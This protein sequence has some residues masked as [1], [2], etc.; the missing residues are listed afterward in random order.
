MSQASGIHDGRQ[1]RAARAILG[2][3]VPDLAAEAGVNRNT[4][5]RVEGLGAIPP[6]CEAAGRIAGALSS[7]GVSFGMQDGQAVIAF[8]VHA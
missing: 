7:R 6:R 1:L 3:S 4:V 5:Y 2:L 8:Q